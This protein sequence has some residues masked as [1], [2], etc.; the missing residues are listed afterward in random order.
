MENKGIGEKLPSTPS[1]HRVVV[2]GASSKPARYS[3][4]AV[5]LLK[6]Q[7]YQVVPVHPKVQTIAGLAVAPNLRSIHGTI[8]TMTLYVSPIHGHHLLDD[9]VYLNPRRVI[10][11]PG[12]ESSQMEKVLRRHH[13]RYFCAC[14]LVLLRTGQF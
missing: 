5:R 9:I 7:G 14:T 13:I 2:L 12:T 4:M 3:N 8:H 6:K 10:F 1:D 11:N